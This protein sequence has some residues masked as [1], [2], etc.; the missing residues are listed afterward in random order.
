MGFE[1]TGACTIWSHRQQ[2]CFGR[3]VSI[4]LKALLISSSCSDT[5]HPR[6]LS[7]PPQ[8]LGQAFLFGRIT[9]FHGSE[10]RYWL[11]PGRRNWRRADGS[12][13]SYYPAFPPFLPASALIRSCFL[14][15]LRSF[16]RSFS[17]LLPNCACV[18]VRKSNAFQPVDSEA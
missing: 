8:E 14:Y 10:D 2:A 18:T 9:G 4:T 16:A 12:T 5:S 13:G 17:E 7:S 11:V 3:C 1:G 15:L 6:E